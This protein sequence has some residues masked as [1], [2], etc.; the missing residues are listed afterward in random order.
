M[1]QLN[2]LILEGNI[3]RV[4]EIKETP[5]HSKLAT[6]SMAVNR[7]Y[8]KSDGTF[9]QEVSY[10]DVEAWGTNYVK[11]ISEKAEKGSGVRIVGRLKQNRWQDQNG[12]WQSRVS[13]VAEHVEFRAK[14]EKKEESKPVEEEATKK[15][16]SKMPVFQSQESKPMPK[17]ANGFD[18]F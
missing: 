12:K 10:F 8:K 11:L 4:P 1:N 7:Y 14:V 18:I 15:N 3:V 17:A 5:N 2:S 6:F 13:V 16:I 9:E